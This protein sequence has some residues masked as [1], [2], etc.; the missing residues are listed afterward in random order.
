MSM[1]SL[2]FSYLTTSYL[3]WF[4]DLT[5]QVPMQ[6]CSLQHQTVLPS[7]VTSTTGHCFHFGSISSFFLV[8][9]LHSS[10]VANCAPTNLRCS[11]FSVICLTFHAVYGVLKARILEWFAIPFS[12][13]PHSVNL[14]TNCG[15][16]LK[17]FPPL[18][19]LS[20]LML[21]LIRIIKRPIV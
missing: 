6:Y 7:P 16:S 20:V 13:G 10:L 11:S 5:F 17:N 2:A 8:L 9:F 18:P 21:A 14:S 4:M 15:K 3:P 1:F 12:S 19:H